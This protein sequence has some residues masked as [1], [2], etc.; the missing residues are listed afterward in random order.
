MTPTKSWVEAAAAIQI[1]TDPQIKY[2]EHGGIIVRQ[3]DLSSWQRCQLQKYYDTEA[4][5][6]PDAPQPRSLSATV[7]GSVMH[8][9]LMVGEGLHHEGRN[10][11]C[12]VAVATFEFYWNPENTGQLPG[13]AP[14]NL[15]LP[16]QTYGGL[17][18][19]G[20][21]VLRDYFRLLQRRDEHL[22]ALEYQFAVP[23]VVQGRIHTLTGT[24]D[25]LALRRKYSKPFVAIDDFKSGK[26]P[27]YLRY[28]QQGS[29][30]AYATTRVEFWRG[31]PESGMGELPTFPEDVIDNLERVFAAHNFRLHTE[32]QVEADWAA[33]YF[34]WINLQELKNVDGGPRNERD[35]ARLKLAIDAYVRANEAGI[36]SPTVTGEVCTFCPF[37]ATC[38][39]IALPDED[40]GA[41]RP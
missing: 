9:A 11:A 35:Y 24:I 7:F 30:Y 3:S 16:R 15:W 34:T 5:N 27:T 12:E 38:G 31:W 26:Q 22:L 2:N 13:V 25:R 28:N 32:H 14:V 4:R 10:D 36:Y 39:G 17:R 21:R 19:R 40:Y 33:R 23:I 18:E 20:R 1:P 37:K 8:Y 6:N 41:L 29:A